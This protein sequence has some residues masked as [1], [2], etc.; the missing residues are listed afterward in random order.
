MLYR[1][2]AILACSAGRSLELCEQ[3]AAFVRARLLL[4]ALGRRQGLLGLCTGQAAAVDCCRDSV[5]MFA[6]SRQQALP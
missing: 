5:L 3:Q 2:V 1:Q 6:L 4:F